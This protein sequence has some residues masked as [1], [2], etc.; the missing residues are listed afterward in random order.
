M[1]TQQRTSSLQVE[2]DSLNERELPSALDDEM[3]SDIERP[4]MKRM[5][6]SILNTFKDGGGVNY[7][8]FCAAVTHIGMP[9]LATRHVFE[10][11][12]QSGNGVVS[13]TEF[14][15]TMVGFRG[16]ILHSNFSSAN[17]PSIARLST[18]LRV[19]R[20]QLSSKRGSADFSSTYSTWTGRGLFP[21]RS[22]T[23][24]WRCSCQMSKMLK[25][26]ASLAA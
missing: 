24:W 22:Y 6:S 14:M 18:I 21:G 10:V 9:M 5:S 26:I 12:D 23:M 8:E 4:S 13:V 19:M 17:A 25:T 16:D 15:S 11:F 7:E 1:D 20:P 3:K 2:I